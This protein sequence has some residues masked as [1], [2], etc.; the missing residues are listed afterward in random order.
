MKNNVAYQICL[1]I[2][3]ITGSKRDNKNNHEFFDEIE[4][5]ND[6]SLEEITPTI[7]FS[8]LEKEEDVTNRHYLVFTEDNALNSAFFLVKLKLGG[9]SGFYLKE[10]EVV[11]FTTKNTRNSRKQPCTLLQKNTSSV[12]LKNSSKKRERLFFDHAS[13]NT[14]LNKFVYH[15]SFV[16]L[17]SVSSLKMLG[18]YEYKQ[19]K[20]VEVVRTL[21]KKTKKKAFSTKR[22]FRLR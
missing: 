3:T 14:E 18:V 15:T 4:C 21:V 22:L 16:V 11:G 9:K 17:R 8:G 6:Y 13:K 12:K 10:A 1:V 2:N 20:I 19:E 5:T 7:G